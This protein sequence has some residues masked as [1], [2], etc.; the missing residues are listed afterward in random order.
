[1]GLIEACASSCEYEK[2]ADMKN[3]IM[4]NHFLTK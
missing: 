2:D 1:M 4:K 3:R